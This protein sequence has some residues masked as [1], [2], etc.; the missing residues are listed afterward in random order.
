M[1]PEQRE[2]A[3]A[4][5]A[6]SA[7][8]YELQANGV[9]GEDLQAAA[10][11]A[12]WQAM[13]D[14]AVG[15]SKDALKRLIFGERPAPQEGG[16]P[17]SGVWKAHADSME[18]ER[19]YWRQRAQTMHEHQEGECW[20]WQGDGGDHPES[21]CNSLPVVI[22]ADALRALI[23]QQPAPQPLTVEAIRE[24]ID[25][26]DLDWE[27]GWSLEDDDGNSVNR[28]LNLAR[29]IERA[30]GIKEQP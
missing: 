28:Y 4:D 16:P 11:G 27:R 18:R 3:A 6:I 8:L 15:M 19:D 10:I 29:A 20:Y 7:V 22:R 12:L 13:E 23:V 24:C 5:A 2:K 26:V 21:M 1:T 30:H 9:E 25:E 17:G 14:E